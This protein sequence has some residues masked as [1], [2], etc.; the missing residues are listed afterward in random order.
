MP[1]CEQRQLSFRSNIVS[2]DIK[3]NNFSTLHT[4]S[5]PK[6]RWR[7]AV[8]PHYSHTRQVVP[9]ALTENCPVTSVNARLISNRSESEYA[10]FSLI[11]AE[12]I[13]TNTEQHGKQHDK[14]EDREDDNQGK[15]R[16]SQGRIRGSAAVARTVRSRTVS[17]IRLVNGLHRCN[18]HI[19]VS[20]ITYGTKEQTNDCATVDGRLLTS[21]TPYHSNCVSLE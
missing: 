21:L 15:F 12:T 8:T 9:Y 19:R 20:E 11:C 10:S 4:S 5:P 13:K 18:E 3:T 7:R 17:V 16:G 2:T 14:Y 6:C 1:L